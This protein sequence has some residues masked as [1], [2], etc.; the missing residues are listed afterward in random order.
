[1]GKFSLSDCLEWNVGL[2]IKG[3]QREE[4]PTLYTSQ[5]STNTRDLP[6]SVWDD[7]RWDDAGVPALS[8]NAKQK[9]NCFIPPRRP[10]L[11]RAGEGLSIG[12][13][14]VKP[15]RCRVFLSLPRDTLRQRPTAKTGRSSGKSFGQGGSCT[16]LFLFLRL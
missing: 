1:M 12:A 3:G 9:L 6:G 14:R 11:H 4:V 7:G 15:L 5:G 2:R 13:C 10:A 16:S 8:W